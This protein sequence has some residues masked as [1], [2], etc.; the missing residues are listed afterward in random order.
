MGYGNG[1]MEDL[2]TSSVLR[3][4]VRRLSS[5]FWRGR[6]V[7]VTGHNGFKGAWLVLMLSS[8]GAR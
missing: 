8:L 5:Q 2:V 6:R 7:L 1:A 4:E 3:E